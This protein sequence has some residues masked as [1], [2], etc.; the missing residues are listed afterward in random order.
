MPT[1]NPDTSYQYWKN[2]FKHKYKQL[3]S[4]KQ[5]FLYKAETETS[6]HATC[7]KIC[8]RSELPSLLGLEEVISKV[9]NCLD[10]GAV[11]LQG[12]NTVSGTKLSAA[13]IEYPRSSDDSDMKVT[14]IR[15]RW[16]ILPAYG[17][18]VAFGPRCMNCRQDFDLV[19]IL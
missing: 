19:S 3:D 15:V 10:D 6:F 5:V 1:S 18:S 11:S 17:F 7:N 4:K 2:I 14:I 8:A 9:N 12:A 16:Y 13:E